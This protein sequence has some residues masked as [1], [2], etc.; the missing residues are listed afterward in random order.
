MNTM[1]F[2]EGIR[3]VAVHLAVRGVMQMLARPAG[4]RPDLQIIELSQWFQNL[5]EKG[6][7][8]VNRAMQMVAEQAV[9][10]ALLVFDGKLSIE[11]SGPKGRFEIYYCAGNCRILLN[12]Q[13]QE[14]LTALFKAK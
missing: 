6:K 5:D 2:L 4:R 1:S 14:D 12:D 11:D 9:Y 7:D 8:M 3:T 10:N 13:S